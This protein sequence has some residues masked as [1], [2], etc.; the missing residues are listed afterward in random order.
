MS[1]DHQADFRD[2]AVQTDLKLLTLP[3]PKEFLWQYVYSTPLA[4][5]VANVDEKARTA[6]ER[7]VI[8][9]WQDFEADGSL[10]YHQRIAVASARKQAFSGGFST[11]LPYPVT[12]RFQ[13]QTS[14]IS[15]RHPPFV[16][17]W[18]WPP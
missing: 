13:V 9:E 18:C 12:I 4:R 7:D 1:P 6:L 3:P 2:T 11:I 14:F 5:M 15:T 17:D 10:I 16:G 8:E